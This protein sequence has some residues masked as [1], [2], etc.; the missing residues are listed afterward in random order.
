[1]R[2]LQVVR[3]GL[4]QLW[5]SDG[6]TCTSSFACEANKPG[7]AWLDL[8]PAFLWGGGMEEA[9]LVS[10]LWPRASRAASLSTLK[11]AHGDGFAVSS[12]ELVPCVDLLLDSLSPQPRS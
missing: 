2:S 12:P 10:G 7:G 8:P 4:C 6:C 9:T 3:L 1:M 11:Q 5:G